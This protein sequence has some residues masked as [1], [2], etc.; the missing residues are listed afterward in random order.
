MINKGKLTSQEQAIE[1]DYGSLRPVDNEVGLMKQLL[2]AAKRHVRDKKMISIRVSNN[3]LEIVRINAYKAGVPYQTYI[4][5]LIHKDA[6]GQ[7][8]E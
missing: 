5:M 1:N 7:L 2:L 8:D 4:N 3:D 6:V